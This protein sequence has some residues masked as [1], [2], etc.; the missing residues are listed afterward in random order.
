A[1]YQRANKSVHQRELGIKCDAVGNN[2]QVLGKPTGGSSR[3]PFCAG[4]KGPRIQGPAFARASYATA[5]QSSNSG[6]LAVS[7]A[8]RRGWARCRTAATRLSSELTKPVSQHA[9]SSDL[10]RWHTAGFARYQS[11]AGQT[12]NATCRPA[13]PLHRSAP[14]CPQVERPNS[15]DG[16]D[17]QPD[18]K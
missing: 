4:G 6:R 17:A 18:V 2:Y 13:L 12:K 10:V 3:E 14:R 8:K 5:E 15:S 16:K 1:G 9:G 7:A 11:G